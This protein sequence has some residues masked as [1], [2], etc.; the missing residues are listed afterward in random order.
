MNAHEHRFPVVSVGLQEIHLDVPPFL[1]NRWRKRVHH[2]GLI[3]VV[4]RFPV[5]F[6]ASLEYEFGNVARIDIAN[7]HGIPITHSTG[8]RS[9]IPVDSDHPLVERAAVLENLM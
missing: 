7:R 1:L 6:R 5:V 8:I 4:G 9:V 2:H 3:P